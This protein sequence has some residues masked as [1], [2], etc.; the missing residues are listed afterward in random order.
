MTAALGLDSI[1]RGYEKKLVQNDDSI[2]PKI[3][4]YGVTRGMVNRA[5]R[6]GRGP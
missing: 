4:S 1:I 2:D 5:D 6:H 3:K